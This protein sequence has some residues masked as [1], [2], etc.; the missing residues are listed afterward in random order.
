MSRSPLLVPLIMTIIVE[1]T[2]ISPDTV[3][4]QWTR[5]P[6]L[7]ALHLSA[8]PRVHGVI[9]N[10]DAVCNVSLVRPKAHLPLPF[11]G[12]GLAPITSAG[13]VRLAD[14]KAARDPAIDSSVNLVAPGIRFR[15]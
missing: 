6:Q 2:P 4:T 3:I 10:L 14:K 8:A 9:G 7:T 11:V 5:Q 13:R 12:T 1:P 15:G